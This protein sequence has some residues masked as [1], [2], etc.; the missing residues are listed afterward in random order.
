MI[1]VSQETNGFRSAAAGATGVAL[2]EVVIAVGILALGMT[3]IGAQLRAGLHAA[4]LT[5]ERTQALM[6][7]ESVLAQIESG[8]LEV[9][10]E[11]A[12]DFGTQYPG[13]AWQVRAEASPIEGLLLITVSVLARPAGQQ[14]EALDPSTCQEILSCRT[15]R[16]EPVPLNLDEIVGE[17]QTAQI[18]ASLPPELADLLSQLGIDPTNLD[19]AS[20]LR[21]LDMQTLLEMLPVLMQAVQGQL[22]GSFWDRMQQQIQAFAA[23]YAAAGGKSPG[24]QTGGTEG[25]VQQEEVRPGPV[26]VPA[27]ASE[28]GGPARRETPQRGGGRGR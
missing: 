9:L 5:Q 24:D 8:T 7:A 22:G 28:G 6:L 15:L 19:V 12:G 14:D 11:A 4:H 13:Y 21:Q 1:R 25:P 3:F 26:G 16:A 18:S 17:E 20:L 2:L 27:P 10:D 23:Q